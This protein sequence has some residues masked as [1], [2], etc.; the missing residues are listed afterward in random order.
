MAT[1]ESSVKEYREGAGYSQEG[2]A[3]ELGV[4]RQTVANIERGVSQPRV[5][6]AIAIGALLGVAVH[7]LFREGLTK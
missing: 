3:R 7:D 5:L 6:L 2:L 1:Y 4:S